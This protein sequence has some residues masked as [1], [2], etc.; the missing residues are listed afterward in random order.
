M[1]RL[2]PP[3]AGPSAP[4]T[5]PPPLLRV[6]FHEPGP[7]PCSTRLGCVSLLPANLRAALVT[8]LLTGAIASSANVLKHTCHFSCMADNLHTYRRIL[9][10]LPLCYLPP[11]FS[12]L[13]AARYTL[14]YRYCLPYALPT[15]LTLLPCAIHCTLFC[16]SALEHGARRFLLAGTKARKAK[17]TRTQHERCRRQAFAFFRRQAFLGARR[18]FSAPLPAHAPSTAPRYY[19]RAAISGCTASAYHHG[20][21]SSPTPTTSLSCHF[22][23]YPPHSHLQPPVDMVTCLP[24]FCSWRVLEHFYAVPYTHLHHHCSYNMRAPA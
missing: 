4:R 24:A 20:S 8:P 23:T 12:Y 11:V 1:A 22:T 9:L 18:V 10:L 7:Y 19:C 16:C 3:Y 21:H 13:T 5:P 6:A 17:M 15:A 2:P 14:F